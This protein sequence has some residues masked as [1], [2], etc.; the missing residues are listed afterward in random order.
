M[1]GTGK[2]S[3]VA[4]LRRR[5]HLAYDVD[6]GFSELTPAD[7]RWHWRTHEVARVLSQAGAATVFV[8]GCSE[9]QQLFT[10]DVTVLLTAPQEVMLERLRNRVG[11][12]FGKTAGE[13]EQV[14]QDL[15]EVEPRLRRAADVVIETT[16]GL[17]GV[18]DQ[19]LTAAGE[20][21]G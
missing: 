6:E 14:L 5:G 17:P 9:E 16:V 18:V 19:V 3:V 4:E 7:G 2:S 12:G 8:A 11:N 10:W 21:G 20:G 1:S 13:R 15:A